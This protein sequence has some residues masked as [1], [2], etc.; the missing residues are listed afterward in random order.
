M[1]LLN[2]NDLRVAFKTA[3]GVVS[4]VNGISFAL[5]KGQTMG[6]V[7][8]SGS[9]KSQLAFAIMGLLARNGTATGFGDV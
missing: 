2:V 4:A 9:G 1:T 8:E 3:D 5:Q 6:I 7:G